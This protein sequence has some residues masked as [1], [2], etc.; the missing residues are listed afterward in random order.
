MASILK[1]VLLDDKSKMSCIEIFQMKSEK[2]RAQLNKAM[3][4]TSASMKRLMSKGRPSSFNNGMRVDTLG[5]ID[6][7]DWDPEG[8]TML[9]RCVLLYL[10]RLD[11]AWSFGICVFKL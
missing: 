4:K 8:R 6:D 7:I 3:C 11:K 10:L 9:S 1:D 2:V 5:N